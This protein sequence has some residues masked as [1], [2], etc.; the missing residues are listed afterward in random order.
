[1]KHVPI[2]KSFLNAALLSG[3]DKQMDYNSEELEFITGNLLRKR[4]KFIRSLI[5]SYEKAGKNPDNMTDEEKLSQAE[6]NIIQ[7][8]AG[9][10]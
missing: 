2:E 9:I 6:K 3:K 8:L 10:N 1:M 5:Q 4:E 7:I